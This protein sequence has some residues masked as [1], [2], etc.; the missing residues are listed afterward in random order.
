MLGE[1]ALKD[2]TEDVGQVDGR[3]IVLDPMIVESQKHATR[4]LPQA[5]R[6]YDA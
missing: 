3:F 4:G 1:E 5:R 6:Q 2:G